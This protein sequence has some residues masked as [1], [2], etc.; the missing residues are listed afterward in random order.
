M[1]TYQRARN[2]F[3]P[4]YISWTMHTKSNYPFPA[5]HRKRSQGKRLTGREALLWL[6]PFKKYPAPPVSEQP[7]VL[8]LSNIG[9]L[10]LLSHGAEA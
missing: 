2:F 1:S 3:V 6:L 8:F 10:V 5:A 9:A 7:P 4:V